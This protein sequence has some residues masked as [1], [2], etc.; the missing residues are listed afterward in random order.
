[1]AWLKHI[2]KSSLEFIFMAVYH[3]VSSN[4]LLVE[5]G[6]F[7]AVLIR[8]MKYATGVITSIS[9]I[10]IYVQAPLIQFEPLATKQI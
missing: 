4:N 6:K 7:Y 5:T 10:V 1:M 8:F 9:Y 2:L 3:F